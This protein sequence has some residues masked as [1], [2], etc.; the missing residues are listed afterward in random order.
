LAVLPPGTPPLRLGFASDLHLG[1]TTPERLVGAVERLLAAAE[2]DLLL[3]GGDYVFLDA[4]PA[5]AA[6]LAELVRRAGARRTL[7]VMGN[8]DLWTE[9]AL[10]ERALRSAGAEVL[11]N[12]GV[13]LGGAHA[14]VWVAGLDDPWSGRPDAAPAFAGSGPGDVRL[15]FSHAPEAL[16]FVAPFAPRLLLVGHTHGGHVAL[17]G[18]RPIVVPG[19]LGRRHPSGWYQFGTTTL[20]VSRG[21]GGVEVAFRTF[22]PPDVVLVDVIPRQDAL[23]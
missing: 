10:L 2:L 13:R 8:H 21:V 3:L 19:P 22:A 1:P 23:A 17:P 9:H 18:G 12:A 11:E 6:R 14:C 20:G 7:A 16:P 15:A 5:K 4:T